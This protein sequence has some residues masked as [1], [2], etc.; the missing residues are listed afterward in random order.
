M[1]A[2]HTHLERPVLPAPQRGF[3][4]Q[5]LN[6]PPQGESSFQTLLKKEVFMQEF[7]A[8]EGPPE[9]SFDSVNGMRSEGENASHKTGNTAYSQKSRE[10]RPERASA[11]AEKKAAVHDEFRDK[12]D[13]T[14]ASD[15]QSETGKTAGA[16][17]AEGAAMA[18][19]G[20]KAGGQT[21]EEALRAALAEKNALNVDEADENAVVKNAVFEAYKA[22]YAK[23]AAADE[24]NEGLSVNAEKSG[25][26][27]LL[28][29]QAAASALVSLEQ[30]TEVPTHK[31]RRTEAAE[32]KAEDAELEN[33]FAS[34]KLN[35]APEEPG[36]SLAEIPAIK[37]RDERT[38]AAAEDKKQA[39]LSSVRYDGKGNAE[40]D[41]LLNPADGAKVTADP[42][43]LGKDGNPSFTAE[44]R[45]SKQANFASML[46]SEIRTNAADLV[47]TGSIILRDGNKGT[48]NLILHPEELGNVK[49]RLQ[50]SDNILTGRITVASEEA[51]K[52]FKANIASLTDAFTASGFDTAGFDLSWSGQE[53]GGGQA[54]GRQAD[55]KNAARNPLAFRYDE[56]NPVL[57]ADEADYRVLESR[58]YVNLIA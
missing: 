38:K 58:P 40:A 11:E 32:F 37:V 27:E 25:T 19:A 54:D 7:K 33:V 18:E 44:V 50:I 3:S 6:T 46:S 29:A 41:I 47:K 36:L 20:E 23:K 17:A 43:V 51:Y 21:A 24:E 1:Q 14:R 13:E 55:G 56:Q 12:P 42:A 53:Q 48:I 52:A 49:I 45:E 4:V 28:S 31:T 9:R 34:D 5:G 15:S 35:R 30:R 26:D 10:D 8:R 2:L 22:P 39:L 16:E 57:D